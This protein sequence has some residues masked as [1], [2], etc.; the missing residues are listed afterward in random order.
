[1]SIYIYI[2]IHHIMYVSNSNFRNSG[3]QMNQVLPFLRWRD[4]FIFEHTCRAFT[5]SP[6]IPKERNPFMDPLQMARGMFCA[7]LGIFLRTYP[8]VIQHFA[9]E[10]GGK[11]L[12]ICRW[13]YLS[14]M[15]V[16]NSKP[17]NDQR[18]YPRFLS[19]PSWIRLPP[20][21]SHYIRPRSMAMKSR[22][23]IFSLRWM[24][25]IILLRRLY[26]LPVKRRMWTLW[27]F[28]WSPMPM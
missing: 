24:D 16:F 25:G 20:I 14:S 8:L 2:C 28:C 21:R 18:V 22:N 5:P 7:S 3:T 15:V 1:M 27:G 19:N 4:M 6:S 13:I 26:T 11:W 12:I 10:S 9:M 23:C 17:F